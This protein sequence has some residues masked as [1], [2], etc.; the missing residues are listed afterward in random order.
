MCAVFVSAEYDLCFPLPC[1]VSAPRNPN[2]NTPISQQGP[3]ICFRWVP[4][5]GVCVCGWVGGGG[6]L[7]AQKNGCVFKISLKILAGVVKSL[8]RPEEHFV[9]ESAALGGG[10]GGQRYQA[11][12]SYFDCLSPPPLKAASPTAFMDARAHTFR[13]GTH[14]C[15]AWHSMFPVALCVCGGG[16]PGFVHVC[17][18]ITHASNW[19]CAHSSAVSHE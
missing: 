17:V 11:Q 3:V 6:G 19:Y 2:K 15:C 10:G 14:T 1:L 8:V 16:G 9:D 13:R 4:V 5:G 7:E 18:R 12:R